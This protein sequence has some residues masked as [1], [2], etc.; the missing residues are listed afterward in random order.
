[1]ILSGWR[2]GSIIKALLLLQRS[3]VHFSA[4]MS[5]GLQ[6]PVLSYSGCWLPWMSCTHAHIH[7]HRHTY[8]H[9]HMQLKIKGIFKVYYFVLKFVSTMIEDSN[10]QLLYIPFPSFLFLPKGMKTR[11]P[12]SPYPVGRCML[13]WTACVAHMFLLMRACAHRY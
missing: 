13:M 7:T 6:L 11:R 3:R 10:L 8:M 1:M 9:T 2:D 12:V 4:S 5:G